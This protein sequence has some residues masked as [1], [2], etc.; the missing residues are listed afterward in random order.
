MP[1]GY[2]LIPYFLIVAP[3]SSSRI[4][5][6][7]SRPFQNFSRMDGS[8]SSSSASDLIETLVS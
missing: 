6:G 5:N 8:C 1:L 3:R 4:G 7:R 2:A